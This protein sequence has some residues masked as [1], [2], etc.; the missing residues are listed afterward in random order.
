MR[1]KLKIDG[2]QMQNELRVRNTSL[3]SLRSGSIQRFR[4]ILSKELID[5]VI[6]DDVA[7]RQII[8]RNNFMPNANSRDS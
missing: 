1:A 2:S 4:S 5:S 8:A 3:R 7:N 6:S